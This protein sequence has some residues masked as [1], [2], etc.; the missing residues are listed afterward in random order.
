MSQNGA[1]LRAI[2]NDLAQ[3]W[4]LGSSFSAWMSSNVAICDTLVDRI[5]SEAIEPIGAIAEPYALWAIKPDLRVEIPFTHPSVIV[6]DNLEP[7]LRLKIHILN[8]GH[9]FLAQ[10]WMSE[11]RS[12]TETVREIL[13]E[14]TIK[15]KLL[16]LYQTEVVPSFVCYDMGD[17][18]ENYV[19]TTIERFENLFLNHRLSD[20]AQNHQLKIERRV[21]DFM[22]W[23]KIRNPTQ[24]FAF[25]ESMIDYSKLMT[26]N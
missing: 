17:A 16:N 25:L 20:I 19:V 3:K 5:V 2:L 9:S 23:V 18:A 14:R 11:K 8:L 21:A 6:T 1:V 7:Y 12:P 22:R 26:H 15:Q 13:A 24:K 4:Q 10:I